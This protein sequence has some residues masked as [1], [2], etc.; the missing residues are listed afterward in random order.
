MIDAIAVLY[1]QA[2]GVLVSA[3][4]HSVYFPVAFGKQPYSQSVPSGAFRVEFVNPKLSVNALPL[5]LR[6]GDIVL[7]IQI[8]NWN[9]LSRCITLIQNTFRISSQYYQTPFSNYI[10]KLCNTNSLT[11]KPD[12]IISP[13]NGCKKTYRSYCRWNGIYENNKTAL[14]THSTVLVT[15]K[16]GDKSRIGADNG[17]IN[18]IHGKH[19]LNTYMWHDQI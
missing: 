7:S 1:R 5:A 13:E 11:E 4:E 10:V 14:L 18:S 3:C 12:R 19:L 6:K 8:P 17:I 2:T 15:R 16:L 9:K